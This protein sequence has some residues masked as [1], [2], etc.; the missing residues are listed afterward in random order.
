MFAGTFNGHPACAAAALA[1]IDKLERE[2]VHAHIFALGARIR[3]EL[4]A[5]YAELGVQ[6]VVAGFGSIFVPYFVSRPVSSYA[7][8]ADNDSELF[9]GY[10]RALLGAGIF[11]LPVNLKRSHVSYAHEERHVD[12][13]VEAT[14]TAVRAVLA[15]R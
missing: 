8:L 12:E 5:L 9:V 7:D 14:G 2:P 3:S 13:L 11:E 15:R 1:T 10:R 6:A 4:E